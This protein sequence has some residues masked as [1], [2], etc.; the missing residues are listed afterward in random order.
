MRVDLDVDTSQLKQQVKDLKQA[1]K[2]V[3]DKADAILTALQD[4]PLVV[5]VTPVAQPPAPVP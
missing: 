5:N 4:D 2:A 1:A 3:V